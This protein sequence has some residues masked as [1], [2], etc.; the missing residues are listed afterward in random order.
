VI[1]Q[2]T[3]TQLKTQAGRASVVLTVTHA[4]DLDRAER[5]MRECVGEVYV[6]AGPRRL[7]AQASGLADISRLAEVFVASDLPVDDLGL[8]RP[9]LDDVFLHLTGHRAEEASAASSTGEDDGFDDRRGRPTDA[10]M[11]GALR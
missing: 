6:E 2:G 8:Q 3:P 1:A 7:T 4:G 10:A 11:E 9:S 5:L